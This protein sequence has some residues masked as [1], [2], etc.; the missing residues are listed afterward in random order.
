MSVL[1]TRCRYCGATLNRLLLTALLQDAGASVS[2]RADACWARD[3]GT[4]HD[5]FPVE[6]RVLQ[7]QEPHQ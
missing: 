3:D 2:H 5:F 6:G 7:P 1:D 4:E